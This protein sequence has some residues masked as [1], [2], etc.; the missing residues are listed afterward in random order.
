VSR[1]LLASITIVSFLVTACASERPWPIYPAATFTPALAAGSSV[2]TIDVLPL[3]LQ[4]WAEPGYDA[5][6]DQL[7]GRTATEIMTV[8]VDTLSDHNYKIAAMI[9]WN[10]DYDGGNALAKDDLMATVGALSHYGA[11][12][13]GHRE[14]HE[15][16]PVPYLPARLG[17]ATGADATLYMGGWSYVSMANEDDGHHVGEAIL[18]GLVIIGVIAAIAATTKSR[19]HSGGGGHSGA[20]GHSGGGRSGGHIGGGGRI[21]GGGHI[22]GAPLLLH[23]P[24]VIAGVADA[25]GRLATDIALTAPAWEE[26]PGLPHDRGPSQMY[27]EMTLIDNHTGLALWHAHQLFPADA[28]DQRDVARAANTMLKAFPMHRG[29]PVTAAAAP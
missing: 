9:D 28:T 13:A 3:D 4:V 7:Q 26:D 20:G 17:T 6:A 1:S 12:A 19:S 22:G 11:A 25:F 5:T 16:L 2:E 15:H 8:A 14:R 29:R 23:H 27:L 24:R 18:L 10:G 21:G